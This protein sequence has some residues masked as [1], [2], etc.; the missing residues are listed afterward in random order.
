MKLITR[1]H[2]SGITIGIPKKPNIIIFYAIDAALYTNN[3]LLKSTIKISCFKSM[4][5]LLTVVKILWL[6]KC[7]FNH[8]TGI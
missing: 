6:S 7:Q 1:T 4:T 2:F 3:I 5:Q 8:G